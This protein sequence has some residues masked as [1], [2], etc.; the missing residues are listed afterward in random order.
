MDPMH[1]P[2]KHQRARLLRLPGTQRSPKGPRIHGEFRV[3][4]GLQER[5]R[6][7]THHPAGGDRPPHGS[8]FESAAVESALA[9]LFCTAL[10]AS[11]NPSLSVLLSI[12]SDMF[13]I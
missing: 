12:R 5:R 3:G 6:P 1:Y 8:D 9:K 10:I 11:P 13:W 4:H 7:Q 2:L